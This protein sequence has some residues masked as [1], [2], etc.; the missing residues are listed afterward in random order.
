MGLGPVPAIREALKKAKMNLK[1]ID[2]IEINEAFAAQIIACHRELNFD[3]S[4]LNVNGGAIALGHPVGAT[5]AKILTTLLYAMEN[6]N[7]SVGL[8]SLCIGGGQGVAMIVERV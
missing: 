2:I 4:I 7:L 8:A 1:D 6:R 3:E 5:G